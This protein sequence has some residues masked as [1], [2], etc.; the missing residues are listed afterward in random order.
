[1]ILV[2]KANASHI[3]HVGNICVFIK[4]YC[5]KSIIIYKT[6]KM[7]NIDGERKMNERT[8]FL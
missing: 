1:M 3:S 5:C 8:V 4:E 7:Y 2:G 6:E